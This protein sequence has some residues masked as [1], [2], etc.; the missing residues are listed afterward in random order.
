V[1]GSVVAGHEPAS[2]GGPS[3]PSWVTHVTFDLH[4]APRDGGVTEG[5]RTA[6]EVNA[7]TEDLVRA[8]LEQFGPRSVQQR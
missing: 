4:Y 2:A 6:D 5:A 1:P 7:A 8:V 3:S